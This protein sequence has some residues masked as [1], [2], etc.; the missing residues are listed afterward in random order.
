MQERMM[1]KT[2]RFYIAL[3]FKL[4]GAVVILVALVWGGRWGFQRLQER[5]LLKQSHAS[6]E[7]HDDR[8]ALIAAQRVF[9]LNPNNADAC[10]MI[11]NV[12]ER[13]NQA[14]AID[15]RKQVV[16]RLPDSADDAVALAATALKFGQLATAEEALAKYDGKAIDTAPYH[17]VRAQLAVAKKDPAAA[18]E[19]YAK[20]AQQDP[21]NKSYQLNLAVFQLGSDSP[22]DNRAG[23]ALLETLLNDEQVRIQAARALRDDAVKRQ[24][25]PAIVKFAALLHDYPE[26]D[27]SE[28]IIYVQLLHSINHPDFAKQLTALQAEAA[29]NPVKLYGVINWMRSDSLTFLAL[30]W[31]KRLPADAIHAA[32]V[33]Q[34]IA[35]CY[36][37]ISDWA[38]LQ[39]WCHNQDWGNVDFLRHSFLARAARERDQSLD[40]RAEWGAALK[41]IGSSGE[42]ISALQQEIAKWGWKDESVELLWLLTKD[43]ERRAAALSTLYDYYAKAG[44]TGDLYRVISRLLELHPDDTAMMNNFAGLSLLLQVENARAFSIAQQL[45]EREPANGAFASTYAYALTL[46]GQPKQALEVMQRLTPE[47]L[48]EPEIATYYGLILTAVGENAKAR[49]Y[50]ELGKKGTLLPEEKVLVDRAFITT[51]R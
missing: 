21:A 16:R 50:L 34:A 48:N 51:A 3:G 20:A 30:D 10:R 8:W 9:E 47:Q 29:G 49:E 7:K 18:R 25:A 11:A 14:V 33:P 26:A 41:A 4:L 32:P 28:R 38:A 31:V 46:K 22:E 42:K 19:H 23:T 17:E 43:T 24:D 13:Q 44:Q 36:A 27:L 39:E 45:Y 40:F 35:N 5:R 6:F 1:Q 12:I 2:E 15:W 37:A